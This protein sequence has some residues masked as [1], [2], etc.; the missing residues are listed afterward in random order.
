MNSMMRNI[1]TLITKNA[2]LSIKIQLK[3]GIHQG[4]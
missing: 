4:G 2:I 1:K 3:N